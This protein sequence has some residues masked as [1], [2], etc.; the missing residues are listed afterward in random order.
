MAKTGIAISVTNTQLGSVPQV[1][2]NSMLIVYG[3]TKVTL[4]EPAGKV[5]MPFQLKTPYLL[6]SV[7][8]LDSLGIDITTNRVLFQQVSDY[9]NPV[10]GAD[11]SGGV[12]WIWGEASGVVS[13]AQGVVSKTIIDAAMGTLVSGFQYR[14]RNIMVVQDSKTLSVSG[15]DAPPTEIPL[16]EV[17]KAID[18]LYTEG[19]C[20]VALVGASV[21]KVINGTISIEDY[22]DLSLVNATMVASVIVTNVPGREACVGKIGG[23]MATISVGTSIGDASYSPFAEALYIMDGVATA[24]IDPETNPTVVYTNTQCASLTLNQCNTLGERQYIFGRTRPPKNGIWLNDGATTA[25][26][27]TALSTLE[28]ARTIAAVVDDLRTYFTPYIN[29]RV[30]VDNTGML[31]S[32]YSQIV[33]DGARATVIQRYKDNGDIS[34]AQIM[35]RAKNDDFIGTRTWEVTVKILPAFTLRWIDGYVFYVSSLS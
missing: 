31:R 10:S 21:T 11:N 8:D 9:F 25:D 32:D 18:S 5:T 7:N 14:P 27:T 3:A 4:P 20:C 35:L 16:L 34:D 23:F 24:P 33:I 30:P 12:L 26:P 28:A 15:A 22:P 1:N 13:T 2:G 29:S 17:Q 19:V 6:R